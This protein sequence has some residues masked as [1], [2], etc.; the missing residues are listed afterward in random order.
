MGYYRGDS[1]LYS[2]LVFLCLYLH[3]KLMS[4]A[5]RPFAADADSRFASVQLCPGRVSRCFTDSTTPPFPSRS[6]AEHSRERL[7]WAAAE[8]LRLL[9]THRL[10]SSTELQCFW[11]ADASHETVVP[12]C[13]AMMLLLHQTF[14]GLE[15][16][17]NPYLS[18]D[19]RRLRANAQAL[20]MIGSPTLMCPPSSDDD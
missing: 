1:R 3:M 17:D 14:Q 9:R 13:Q 2:V 16:F 19:D 11:L 20:S 12:V 18:D 10:P 4:A 7:D 5:S 8:Y 15:H 6:D